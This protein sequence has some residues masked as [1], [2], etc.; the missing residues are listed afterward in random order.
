MLGRAR[1]DLRPLATERVKIFPERLNVL[2][3]VLIQRFTGL[4]RFRNDPIVNVG[5]VHHLGDAQAFEL[6][7]A[8]QN[9]GRNRR[10]KITDVAKIPDGRSAVIEFRFALNQ[11]TK[12][13]ELT[14]ECVVDAQHALRV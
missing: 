4:T 9:V 10:T 6:Q 13:F 5:Q 7:I 8:A 1:R 14:R 12:L 3:G 11:R 2:R